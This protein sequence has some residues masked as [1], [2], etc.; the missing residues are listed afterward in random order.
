MRTR[1]KILYV[2]D[3]ETLSFVTRDNLLQRGYEVD[4]CMDGNKGFER[5]SS[6]SYDL[7]I[8][9]V[10][11]PRLDGFSLAKKVRALNDHIPIIFLTA[12]SSKEDKIEGLK[13]GADDYITKPYSIEELILKIEIFLKRSHIFHRESGTNSIRI[14]NLTLFPGNMEIGSGDER[15]RLTQKESELLVMLARQPNSIVR[16]DDILLQVWGNDRFFSSRSLDVF[17]SRLRK[18]LSRDPEV[19]IESIH[20]VGYKMVWL[21]ESEEKKS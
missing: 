16:R 15:I 17:I 1:A 18:I 20:N 13:L 9:D 14:G 3:D 2:E 8:F 12:R 7:C 4:H 11:L 5:F 21:S 19:R 6:N 10:M